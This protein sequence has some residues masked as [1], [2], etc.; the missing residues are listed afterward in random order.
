VHRI[1]KAMSANRAGRMCPTTYVLDDDIDPSN[2]SDVLWALGTRI[3]PNLRHEEWPG[4]ILPWYL[5]YTEK[6]RHSA[7]GAVVVH[8]GLLPRIDDARVRPATFD[9]LYSADLRARVVA[10]ESESM[11]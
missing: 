6:E 9:N 5:C 2:M 7:Q 8:D 4:T 3:H 11:R 10:A 1:G